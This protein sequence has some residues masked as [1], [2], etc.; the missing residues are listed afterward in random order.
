LQGFLSIGSE[1]GGRGRTY[2]ELSTGTG[3]GS[4]SRLIASA[5]VIAVRAS[6]RAKFRTEPR[7]S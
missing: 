4:R 7:F 5:S 2:G 6:I 1:E 3:G